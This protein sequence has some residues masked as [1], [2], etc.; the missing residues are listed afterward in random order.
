MTGGESYFGS[1]R[2]R[3]TEESP[4]RG[5]VPREEHASDEAAASVG[6]AFAVECGGLSH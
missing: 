6:G 2:G 3:E 4:P 1:R 5:S